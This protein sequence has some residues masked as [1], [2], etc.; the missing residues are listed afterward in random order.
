M[1]NI[2][3]DKVFDDYHLGFEVQSPEKVFIS[4][5]TTY[6]EMTAFP[7]VLD[8]FSL[9][10]KYEGDYRCFSFTY[11]V[12]VGNVLI[13]RLRIRQDC[14]CRTDIA[15]QSYWSDFST[16]IASVF[17]VLKQRLQTD[18][19][20]DDPNIMHHSDTQL[21]FKA[22]H[23][24][25]FGLCYFEN[26][27]V[28]FEII[29]AREYPELLVDSEY[30]NNMRIDGFLLIEEKMWCSGSYKKDESIQR[31]PPLLT[32]RFGAKP[33]CWRDDKN[34]VFGMADEQ[35]ARIYPLNAFKDNE[36]IAIERVFPA[37]GGGGDFVMGFGMECYA[38]DGIDKD[39]E[40]LIGKRIRILPG[41][42]DC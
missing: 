3:T 26:H 16:D 9:N 1:R 8:D 20:Q 7:F 12:R 27:S 17:T 42:Y 35:F 37:K 6:E 33:V 40:T 29:N 28:L 22:K 15:V 38:F 23:E 39:F 32:E 30:E 4:W 21:W 5:D 14:D 18:L 31:R 2:V 10:A 36:E 34:G 19:K 13:P 24:I 25:H 41:I 11:P